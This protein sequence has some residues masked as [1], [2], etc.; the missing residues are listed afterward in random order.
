[1]VYACAA[2]LLPVFSSEDALATVTGWPSFSKPLCADHVVYRRDGQAEEVLCARSQAHLGHRIET[3]GRVS[4]CI[5]AA[6][7]LP[8]PTTTTTGQLPRAARPIGAAEL[9]ASPAALSSV[10]SRGRALATARFCMGCFW[11]VQHLFERVPGVLATT[12]G[13]SDG[14]EAL[15]V[16]FDPQH[17][18]YADL[19]ELFF[20]SHDFTAFRAVGEKAATGRYRNEVHALDEEQASSAREV[21]AQAAQQHAGR[22]ATRVLL[23][24]RADF[25]SAPQDQQHYLRDTARRDCNKRPLHQLAAEPNK[26]QD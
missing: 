21:L 18:S 6:A 4:F 7:L 20:A 8:L 14:C 15:E 3:G 13:H 1:M 9:G 26:L 23:R 25:T 22:V 17:V 5:N 19:C 11:A 12:A 2:S 16:S 10:L 24:S